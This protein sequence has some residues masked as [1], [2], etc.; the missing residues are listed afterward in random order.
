MHNG[1]TEFL[2]ILP[3]EKPQGRIIIHSVLRCSAAVLSQSGSPFFEQSQPTR[4]LCS[5]SKQSPGG[6]KCAALLYASCYKITCAYRLYVDPLNT[7]DF[8]SFFTQ[9][10]KFFVCFSDYIDKKTVQHKIDLREFQ[11]LIKLFTL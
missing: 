9:T 3:C 5:C 1:K 10:S 6:D 2:R 8:R 11:T 4:K 7:D